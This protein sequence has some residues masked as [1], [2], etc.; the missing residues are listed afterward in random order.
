MLAPD[1]IADYALLEVSRWQ[2]EKLIQ[3]NNEQKEKQNGK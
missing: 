3:K 2:R 1:A